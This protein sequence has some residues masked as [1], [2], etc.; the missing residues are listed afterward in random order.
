MR[1]FGFRAGGER[2]EHDRVQLGAPLPQQE[3]AAHGHFEGGRSNQVLH[4]VKNYCIIFF[5]IYILTPL[6]K[7]L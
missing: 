7:E 2:C 4:S 5:N 1:G 6:P 3:A